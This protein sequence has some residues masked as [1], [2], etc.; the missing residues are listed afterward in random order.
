M[1]I[2]I[3]CGMTQ[4]LGFNIDDWPYSLSQMVHQTDM[5]APAQARE[6][7][8]TTEYL[9]DL[10]NVIVPS[11]RAKLDEQNFG[12]ALFHAARA[13]ETC[14][15]TRYETIILGALLMRAGAKIRPHD[16][17]HL[18]DIVDHVPCH[19]RYTWAMIDQ[20][21]RSPGKAQFKAALDNYRVGV[22]R[23]F[24]ENR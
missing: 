22:P 7:Y 15:K 12:A 20:G 8:K 6:F 10:E 11:V 19:A 13:R 17:Q 3:A 4:T 14:E 2:D 24:Q 16:M 18:R 21:F 23:N 9:Q 1:D 5:M